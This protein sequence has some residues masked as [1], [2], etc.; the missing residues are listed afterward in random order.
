MICPPHRDSES[1]HRRSG[2]EN[3]GPRP[4]S[5]GRARAKRRGLHGD[6]AESGHET[7]RR[8]RSS[9]YQLFFSLSFLSLFPKKIAGSFFLHRYSIVAYIVLQC[10][11]VVT[12]EE[13]RHV[14][15]SIPL[16]EI[17]TVYNIV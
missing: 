2:G 8:L 16:F 10:Y 5:P 12:R 3:G 17:S 6:A 7:M 9:F 4:P 11:Q 15:T 13:L 14:F 1:P